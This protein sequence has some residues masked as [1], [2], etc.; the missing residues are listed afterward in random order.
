MSR[1]THTRAG[2]ALALLAGAGVAVALASC[3]GS[4]HDPGSSSEAATERQT[5]QRLAEFAHCM[6]EHG[7]QVETQAGTEGHGLGI[8]IKGSTGKQS[9]EAAQNACAKYAPRPQKVNLSPQQKVEQEERVR[10]FASCMREHGIKLHASASE[11]HIQIGIGPNSGGPNPGTATFQKAQEACRGLLPGK[12]GKG[13]GP[14][15]PALSGG[16]KTGPDMS[17]G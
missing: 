4:S 7:V 1:R 11:G 5:E 10:K 15:L 6:R 12:R 8:S 17:P 3:G 14:V 13:P 16:E 9:M 2:R